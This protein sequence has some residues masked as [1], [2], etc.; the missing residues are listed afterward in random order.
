MIKIIA[1]LSTL[2]INLFGG[3]ILIATSNKKY[4][5]RFFLG[6]F[7]F[8]SFLLFVGHFLSFNEYW[9]IFR[10]FDFIFLAS[11]LAFYP[12]YYLY[13][14]S[15]FNFKIAPT[16]WIYHFIP[17][18][19]IAILMLIATSFSSWDCYLN[20]MNNNLY[21]SALESTNATILAYLY[22]GSRLF[23][24]A[25]IVIYVFLTIHYILKAKKRMNDL[26]SNFDMYQIRFF[27]I[28][29]ISFIFLMAIPGFFLL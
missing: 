7:F 18:I 21:N 2:F 23:H 16:K 8:N 26:F 15:A 3:I 12:L 25:Q 9:V 4:K 19:L 6:L 10:Y 11:L 20:Y 24:L 28:V 1:I 5:N 22:K 29:T 14:F 27:Y 13:I 17:S